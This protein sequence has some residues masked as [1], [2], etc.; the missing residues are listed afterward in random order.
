MPIEMPTNGGNRWTAATVS[1]K[2]ERFW[3]RVAKFF[4][5]LLFPTLK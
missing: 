4:V 2:I 5:R 3:F 1:G